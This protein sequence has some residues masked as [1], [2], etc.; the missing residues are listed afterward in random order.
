[1]EIMCHFFNILPQIAVNKTNK[2][3]NDESNN[4]K[5]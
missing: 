4:A 5:Y 1:M 2:P 3:S